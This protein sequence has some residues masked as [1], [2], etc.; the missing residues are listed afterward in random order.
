ME[1]SDIEQRLRNLAVKWR[2]ANR[3]VHDVCRDAAEEIRVLRLK[4]DTEVAAK[5]SIVHAYQYGSGWG[6]GKD[7]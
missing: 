6:K 7:E 1:T 5:D 2:D 4:H 3:E